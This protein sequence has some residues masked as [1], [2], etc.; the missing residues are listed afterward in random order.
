[1]STETGTPT[2]TD[3]E[4][5][6]VWVAGALGGIAGGVVFGVMLQQ[7]MR[8][9]LAGAIPALWGLSGL[10]AGWLVHLVNSVVLGLL[11]AAAVRVTGLDAYASAL[12]SGWAVGVAWGIVL[13]IVGAAVIMPLW[14]SAVGFPRVPPFPNFNP[15][16][17][18]GHVVYGAVL[19]LVYAFVRS[20]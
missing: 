19:G 9:V 8:P 15:Q 7:M 13:W 11:F 20:R 6:T 17:I 3:T 4:G 18:P 2:S 12:R 10:S 5:A 1:M 14:L 16:S